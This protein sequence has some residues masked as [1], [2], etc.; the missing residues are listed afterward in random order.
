MNFTINFSVPNSLELS[1]KRCL[2][3]LLLSLGA[4]FNL[5]CQ[6]QSVVDSNSLHA[7]SSC[8]VREYYEQDLVLRGEN[9]KGEIFGLPGGSNR[10]DFNKRFERFKEPRWIIDGFVKLPK[11]QLF[12]GGEHVENYASLDSLTSYLLVFSDSSILSGEVLDAYFDN[13]PEQITINPICQ[14]FWGT[15]DRRFVL[16]VLGKS[17]RKNLNDS[18]DFDKNFAMMECR[19]K[20]TLFFMGVS[21]RDLPKYS[22]FI[23][24]TIYNKTSFRYNFDEI[25]KYLQEN[26]TC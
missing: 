18:G 19:V 6:P 20:S 25:K 4:M 15:R 2:S 13:Q 10:F 21:E 24:K 3:A 5:A 12:A 16:L 9:E 23:V 1:A 17:W 14:I 22:R 7:S 8:E 26:N 11:D